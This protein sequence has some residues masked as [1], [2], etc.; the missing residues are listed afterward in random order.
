ME[1]NSIPSNE[2]R[3]QPRTVRRSS[4]GKMGG[5][6]KGRDFVGMPGQLLRREGAMYPPLPLR[7]AMDAWEVSLRRA[8]SVG[9]HEYHR[10]SGVEFRKLYW[11]QKINKSDY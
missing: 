5:E 2:D 6:D 10:G 3:A 4:T 8:V 11:K 9:H 7:F 1:G